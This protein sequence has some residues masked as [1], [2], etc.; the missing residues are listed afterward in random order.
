MNITRRNLL[1]SATATAVVA[2]GT[3]TATAQ[4]SAAGTD[5]ELFARIGRFRQI[6]SEYQAAEEAAHMRRA[7]AEADPYCPPE[8]IPAYDKAASDAWNAFMERRG[9]WAAYD[10]WNALNERCID[11]ARALFP[12]PTTTLEGALAKLRLAHFLMDQYAEYES[13]ELEFELSMTRAVEADLVQ[14]VGGGAS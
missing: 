12:T 4:V 13:F 1:A 3:I 11:V 10:R 14:L 7:E 5:A 2:G 8:V 6:F 9:V